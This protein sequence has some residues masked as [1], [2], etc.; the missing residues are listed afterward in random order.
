MPTATRTTVALLA[1]VCVGAAC[2]ASSG[3]A[4]AAGGDDGGGTRDGATSPGDDSGL[5]AEGATPDGPADSGAMP[6]SCDGSV[7]SISFPTGTAPGA[8]CAQCLQTKCASALTTCA[9]DCLCASSVACLASHEDNYT[10]CPDALSAIGA[11]NPGLTAVAGCIPMNCL[12]AC[13]GQTD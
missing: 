7:S 5:I 12:S 9:P 10:L 13:N 11:G 3:G 1:A 2:S 6:L 8:A 4:P